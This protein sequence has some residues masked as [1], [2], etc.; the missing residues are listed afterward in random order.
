MNMSDVTIDATTLACTDAAWKPSSSGLWTFQQIAA[1]FLEFGVKKFYMPGTA[2]LSQCTA[3]LYIVAGECQETTAT[4]GKGCDAFA[5]GPS[6]VF[7]LD[8]MRTS[9]T[10]NKVNPQ[11]TADG[12][13]MNLCLSGFGAGY[14]T[15]T[16]YVDPTHVA[17]LEGDSF[18]T[19]MGAPGLVNDYTCPDPQATAGSV[20]A[21]FIGTFCHKGSLSRWS[22]CPAGTTAGCCG[23][24][25][26][27][28]N[29]Y[30]I[31]FP[32]YYYQKAQEHIQNGADFVATCQAA[33]ASVGL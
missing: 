26:G 20:Y 22:A 10:G 21:N 1:A 2:V 32:D 33:M 7:Q 12:N 3:A 15:A 17:T 19:C 11:I 31:P 23:V 28:A 29:S 4:L 8:F 5:T 30:Q 25:N 9:N 18:Y 14:L 6:G 24:W 27:G 16:P 13:I